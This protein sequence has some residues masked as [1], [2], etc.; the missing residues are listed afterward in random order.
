MG[1]VNV[2]AN[3]DNTAGKHSPFR[4]CDL[5]MVTAKVQ[6]DDTLTRL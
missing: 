3:G 4:T 1:S 2:A 5:R 6:L